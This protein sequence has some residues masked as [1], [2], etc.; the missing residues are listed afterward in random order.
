MTRAV[1]ENTRIAPGGQPGPA[2]TDID[3]SGL[4]PRYGMRVSGDC[5]MPEIADDDLL[6]FDRREPV[7]AG[8][9]VIIYFRPEIVASGEFQ[10]KVKRL[11]TGVPFHVTFPWRDNPKSDGA[12]LI[13]AETLNPRRQ[14]AYPC[15]EILA[16]HKCLRQLPEDRVSEKLPPPLFQPAEAARTEGGANV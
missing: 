1:S 9:L 15:A 3:P 12:A 13:V 14:F 5:M 6:L 11:V 7:A 16:I 2:I 8:D 4:P 10:G